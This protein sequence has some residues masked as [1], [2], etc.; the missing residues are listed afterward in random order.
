MSYAS[1]QAV[2]NAQWNAANEAFITAA[3]ARSPHV[4]MR[5]TLSVDGNMYCFLYGDDLVNGIAGFGET[6][7]AAAE[8]FDR[9][10]CTQKA[11]NANKEG[12]W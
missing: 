2:L 9:N 6:A 4:L 5:P 8:D 10:W 1:E 3:M 11:P 12:A 7:A